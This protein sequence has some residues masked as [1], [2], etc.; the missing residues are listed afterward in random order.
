MF[1]V[2]ENHKERT[3]A[4]RYVTFRKKERVTERKPENASIARV[5]VTPDAAAKLLRLSFVASSRA[6]TSLPT[7]RRNIVRKPRKSGPVV[8]TKKET[9]PTE[10]HR[11]M[12]VRRQARPMLREKTEVEDTSDLVDAAP[13]TPED[14]KVST[15]GLR[16]FVLEKLPK[17]SVLRKVILSGKEEL[18]AEEFM[19]KMEVWLVLFN[20]EN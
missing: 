14:T 19:A 4:T 2:E 5:F 9:D 11:E 15:E 10:G 6:E 7:I 13:I 20:H 18:T 17:E 12:E 16:R 3:P 8:F 1:G